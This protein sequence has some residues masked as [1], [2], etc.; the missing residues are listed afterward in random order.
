[1]NSASG[2]AASPASRSAC[3]GRGCVIVALIVWSLADAVFPDAEPRAR[4]GAYVVMA[5]VAV[6]PS[7]PRCSRTSSATRSQARREGMEIDGITLWL[8]GGVA[9]FKGMFPSAGAEFRIAIAGPVVS[10]AIGAAF[11]AAALL[12][13]SRRGRRGRR[14]GSATST[15]SCWSST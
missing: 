6:L 10:L 4:H 13:R 8:F 2:S 3:T 14:S 12:V 1:M 9:R 15:S 7:S 11:A 5:V